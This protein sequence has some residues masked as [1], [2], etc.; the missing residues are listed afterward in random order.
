MQEHTNT[1]H[2]FKLALKWNMLFDAK[3]EDEQG[4]F[5]TPMEQI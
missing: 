3:L 2:H 1:I 4:C 5:K